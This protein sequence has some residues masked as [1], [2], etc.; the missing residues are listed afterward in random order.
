MRVGSTRRNKANPGSAGGFSLVELLV[1]VCILG[2][3]AAILFP[4]FTKAKESAKVSECL[5]NMRQ[6]GVGLHLYLDEYNGRFPSAVPCGSPSFWSAKNRKTLQELLANYVQ[7]GLTLAD[8][9]SHAV[10]TS[11]GVFACPSDTGGAD[12]LA[13]KIGIRKDM[14]VWKSTGSSYEYYASLQ[15]DWDHAG[16]AVPWTSLAPLIVVNGELRRVGA[17]TWAFSSLS[18]KAVLG[19]M[20]YWHMG[21]RTPDNCLAYC[22]TLFADGHAER[23]RGGCHLEARLERLKPW[24]SYTEMGTE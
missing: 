19:D 18:R 6:I 10:Y 3:L 8:A 12:D 24:H 14:A 11:A 7:K 17:P 1:V 2:V 21:D 13:E 22:N 5:S 16:V 23:V 20:F 15:E 9:S 4:I